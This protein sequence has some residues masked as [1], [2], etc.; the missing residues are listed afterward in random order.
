MIEN[1]GG[2]GV[3]LTDR[4]DIRIKGPSYGNL[5]A[6]FEDPLFL[7]NRIALDAHV[8]HVITGSGR[9]TEKGSRYLQR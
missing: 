1:R 7:E 5:V 4:S 6:H 9:I 8:F 2:F 3:V